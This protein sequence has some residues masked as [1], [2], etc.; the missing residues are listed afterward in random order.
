MDE[1]EA[2][3]EK[4]LMYPPD[5]I[6]TDLRLR[7]HRHLLRFHQEGQDMRSSGKKQTDIAHLLNGTCR[8][9]SLVNDST[10]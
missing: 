2:V 1:V 9:K 4:D 5:G 8:I 3:L 7:P 6:P 10:I